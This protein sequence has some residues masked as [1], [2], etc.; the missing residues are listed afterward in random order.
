MP[1]GDQTGKA[2]SVMN[3]IGVAPFTSPNQIELKLN[4]SLPSGIRVKTK[5]LPSG[6]KLTLP[7]YSP[8]PLSKRRTGRPSSL[9]NH[10]SGSVVSTV[11]MRRRASETRVGCDVSVSLR[12]RSALRVVGALRHS[13]CAI[14]PCAPS[15]LTSPCRMNHKPAA[16]HRNGIERPSNVRRR[17]A[18]GVCAKAMDAAK[19]VRP[20]K[21]ESS[22]RKERRVR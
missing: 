19:G 5:C 17:G 2:A 16:S 8:S 3:G 18:L 1:S 21:M 15:C 11:R 13:S 7:K 4:V 10:N 12:M 22:K 9:N 20:N 6:A 14:R